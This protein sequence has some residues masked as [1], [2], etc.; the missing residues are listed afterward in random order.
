MEEI[1]NVQKMHFSV[2]DP[3]TPNYGYVPFKYF[4]FV[5]L[6]FIVMTFIFKDKIIV[7]LNKHVY[8]KLRKYIKNEK[9]FTL[10][11]GLIAILPTII[12]LHYD[13][14][15]RS[16]SMTN[17]GVTKYIS[18]K[19]INEILRF[20]GAYVIIQVAAQDLGTVEYLI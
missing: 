1:K 19:Y 2:E 16:F 5:I 20:M 8:S 10:I 11:R 18:D 4:Q 14:K 3:T 17:L 7:Q 6:I 13:V 12:I 15:Y 9:I